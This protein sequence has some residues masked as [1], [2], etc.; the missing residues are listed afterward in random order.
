MALSQ[1]ML[2]KT[3]DDHSFVT[4]PNEINFAEIDSFLAIK[5]PQMAGQINSEERYEK[6]MAKYY[7]KDSDEE[8]FA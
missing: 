8:I 4:D 5:R 2:N 1:V 7:P 6:L 3:K